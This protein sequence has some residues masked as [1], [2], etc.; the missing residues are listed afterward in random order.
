MF[1]F[2][3][4]QHKTSFRTRFGG[5]WG[6]VLGV[7][8]AILAGIESFARRPILK[9]KSEAEKVILETRG[10]G[11][12]VGDWWVTGGSGGPNNGV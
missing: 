4:L 1:D 3:G 11:R 9:P 12:E 7:L 2:R 8:W 10:G 6:R 5:V